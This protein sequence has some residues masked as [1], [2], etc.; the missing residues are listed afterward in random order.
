MAEKP[1]SHMVNLL[2]D[3][4]D[5]RNFD[6]L[7]AILEHSGNALNDDGEFPNPFLPHNP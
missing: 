5:S 1:Y 4:G 7:V 6:A 3:P 2:N